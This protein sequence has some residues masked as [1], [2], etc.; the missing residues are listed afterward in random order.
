M[1]NYESFFAPLVGQAIRL[2]ELGVHK[3]ASL[4]FWRDYFQNAVIVGLDCKPVQIDDPA[5]MIHVY[6]GYKQDTEI[7]GTYP[8]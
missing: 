7:Q 8:Y 6:Q 5:G 4:R 1:Q 2:L 3:G